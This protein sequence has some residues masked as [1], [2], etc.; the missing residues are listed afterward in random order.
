MNQIQNEPTRFLII[1]LALLTASGC[2]DTSAPGAP[3]NR[4]ELLATV[5]G[6]ASRLAWSSDGTQL[7]FATKTLNAVN[8]S[9]HTVRQLDQSPSINILDLCSAGA[10]IYFASAVTLPGSTEPNFRVSRVNPTA[11]AA[12][13]LLTNPWGGSDRVLVSDDERFLV[14][15]GLLY[16]VQ[17]ATQ[18]TLPGGR[19]IGFSPDGTQLLYYQ[20]QTGSSTESPTLISTADGS[21]SQ[22]LHSPSSFYSG[23]RWEGNSPQLIDFVLD[24]GT[25][26][27]FEIDGVTGVTRD[28]AQFGANPS[29][30]TI[31]PLATWSAD[32]RTLGVWVQQ[33]SGE[34]RTTNLYVIRSGSAPAVVA[35]L[36]T[37]LYVGVGPP[38]F[39]RSGNSVGYNY[40]ND[41]AR[42]LYVKSGI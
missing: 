17:A 38:V 42:S 39:S 41:S 13:I 4:G 9:T 22:T 40:Y 14:A 6:G 27:L 15:N 3:E 20:S 31:L 32:N 16:D 10:R 5:D 24:N 30:P 33:G 25:L 2:T 28:L 8:V 29:F 1:S 36:T 26:R 37:S 23:H 7:V 12:E 21:S 11:G 19:P 18:I 34:S 35:N